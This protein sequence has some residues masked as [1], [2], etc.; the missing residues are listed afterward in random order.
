MGNE[1]GKCCSQTD[2][3][4]ELTDGRQP[5]AAADPG[6][7]AGGP[8]RKSG[9]VGA[10]RSN[11]FAKGALQ[12]RGL[13]PEVSR[14]GQHFDFA[15]TNGNKDQLDIAQVTRLQAV[16]RGF[17]QRRKYRLHT[18]KMHHANGM[19]FKREELFETL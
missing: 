18:T 13:K 1:C 3:D 9:V 16:V 11:D 7:T 2:G 10:R 19:Y 15:Y 17:I 5:G 6:T 14:S 4:S 12:N 8:D